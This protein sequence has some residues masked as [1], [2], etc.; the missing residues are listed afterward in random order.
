MIASR[1]ASLYR[2]GS[3]TPIPMPPPRIGPGGGSFSGRSNRVRGTAHGPTIDAIGI[4]H[5]LGRRRRPCLAASGSSWGAVAARE[6]AVQR[7]SVTSPPPFPEQAQPLLEVETAFGG[8]GA[9]SRRRASSARSPLIHSS[10]IAMQSSIASSLA[11]SNGSGN[12]SGT[13]ARPRRT[14]QRKPAT[15][16]RSWSSGFSPPKAMPSPSRH[17]DR[18]VLFPDVPAA[19]RPVPDL[20]RA[21]RACASRE[22]PR[23][24]QRSSCRDAPGGHGEAEPSVETPELEHDRLGGN[25]FPAAGHHRLAFEGKG[26]GGTYKSASGGRI[27][28]RRAGRRVGSRSRRQAP[29]RADRPD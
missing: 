12:K 20:P 29:R 2:G 27:W 1:D 15:S 9:W 14:P 19:L 16:R 5:L 8:S 21:S 25:R 6:P 24:G 7:L 3:C 18:A 23:I 11:S 17:P 4:A 26:I 22:T 10:K 28:C 13:R